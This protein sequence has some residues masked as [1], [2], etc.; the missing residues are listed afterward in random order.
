M[1]E[2][3]F[4]LN[5][6]TNYLLLGPIEDN[7]EPSNNTLELLCDDYGVMHTI[8]NNGPT[9]RAKPRHGGSLPVRVA[10]R[11]ISVG[12][13]FSGDNYLD[14]RWQRHLLET[15]IY[16]ERGFYLP[17]FQERFDLLAYLS[18]VHTQ[19][20]SQAIK[21]ALAYSAIATGHSDWTRTALDNNDIVR[22][23]L[24]TQIENRGFNI[25]RPLDQDVFYNQQLLRTPSYSSINAKLGGAAY[26]GPI[27][28]PILELSGHPYCFYLASDSGTNWSLLASAPESVTTFQNH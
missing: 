3:Y 20:R 21:D 8:L 22:Q 1:N 25:C 11:F 24:T 18:I 19:F 12:A 9:M 28:P 15:R 5:L 7:P 14:I 27:W 6:S 23:L 4:I 16:N 2:M 10:G 26:S 13:R 17:S